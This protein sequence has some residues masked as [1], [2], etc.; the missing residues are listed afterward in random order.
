[1]R[2]LAGY[3]VLNGDGPDEVIEGTHE[4]IVLSGAEAKGFDSITGKVTYSD[5]A[6]MYNVMLVEWDREHQIASR[7]G[8]GRISKDA[9]DMSFPTIRFV[10]LG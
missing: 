8:I 7:L 6:Q 5:E 1:M 9:W 2:Q 3:L 4:F 10:T